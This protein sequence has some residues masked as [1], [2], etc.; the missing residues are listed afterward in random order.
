MAW[1]GLGVF[2]SLSK[3]KKAQVGGIILRAAALTGARLRVELPF[4]AGEGASRWR[5]GVGGVGRG[6]SGAES[7][8]VDVGARYVDESA[9][10]ARI[11]DESFPARVGAEA[12]TCEM[13]LFLQR[14]FIS[15]FVLK[16]LEELS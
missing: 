14:T 16:N 2:L 15:R 10:R 12:A 13:A 1:G 11:V 6:S 9:A 8:E 3:K 7:S 5:R 4:L